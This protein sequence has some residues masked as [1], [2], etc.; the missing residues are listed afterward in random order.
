MLSQ[1]QRKEFDMQKTVIACFV[2]LEMES[3]QS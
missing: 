1:E 2:V 3:E